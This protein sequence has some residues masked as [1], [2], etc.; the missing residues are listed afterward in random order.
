MGAREGRGRDKA[1]CAHP[2]RR[3]RGVERRNSGGRKTSCPYPVFQ[4]FA[5]VGG[6]WLLCI[7]G[8]CRRGEVRCS[9]ALEERKGDEDAGE[10][11]R[12]GL[13]SDCEQ[14]KSGTSRLAGLDWI[15]LD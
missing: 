12:G 15:G 14:S 8:G 13:E 2:T 6:L 11:R 1:A 4:P 3:T 10:S 7:G 5:D 9:R